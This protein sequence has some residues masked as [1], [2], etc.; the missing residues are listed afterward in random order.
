MLTGFS[1]FLH[2]AHTNFCNES[3]RIGPSKAR[4]I[5]SDLIAF[6]HSVLPSFVLHGAAH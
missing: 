1:M 4:P 5:D 6:M 2:K 3:V